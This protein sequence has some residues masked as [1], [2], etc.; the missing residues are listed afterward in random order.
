M[1]ATGTSPAV[2]PFPARMAPEIADRQLASLGNP[3]VVM[4]PMMGSGT[5]ILSAAQRGHHAIGV[6]SD[7]LSHIIVAAAAGGYDFDYVRDAARQIS[8]RDRHLGWRK[9]M[10]RETLQFVDYWFDR[11]TQWKLA[12]IAEGIRTSDPGI[13]APLWCA[14]SR[15]IITKDSGASRA[16]DVSHSRPHRVRDRATLDP[17]VRFISSVETVLRRAA[18]VLAD[19]TLSLIRS[20]ARCLPFGAGSVA[21]VVTSPPYLNAI[22]YLRGHRMS[23]V[24]MG[25]S[26]A[27][28]RELRGTNIG[29]ERGSSIDEELAVVARGAVEGSVSTRRRRIIATY[30]SD[31]D[32]V[33]AEVARVVS[34]DGTATFVVADARHS[35]QVVSVSKLVRELAPRHSLIHLETLER[36]LPDR[37]R[38]LP[39]PSTSGARLGRRMR[40]ESVITFRR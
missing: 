33:L 12:T 10:D 21:H 6:D 14:M 26:M 38:Y 39:P 16:R 18:P 25:Y 27:A 8:A 2:H 37:H 7:P 22:D 36:S 1:S 19:G 11:S 29:T 31:I 13:R 40:T 34:D 3:S 4:D 20:D 15:L 17:Q 28:L 24:W 30:V 32:A 35:D 5:F 9:T 23:L